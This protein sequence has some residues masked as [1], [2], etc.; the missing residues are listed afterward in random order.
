VQGYASQQLPLLVFR[1]ARLSQAGAMV[2]AFQQ[3]QQA[4]EHRVQQQ[5]PHQ[6]LQTR[7]LPTCLDSVKDKAK[8]H[9]RCEPM[10]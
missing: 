6:S 1:Q 8:V 3:E 5:H 7:T 2:A 10:S 4:V 9:H